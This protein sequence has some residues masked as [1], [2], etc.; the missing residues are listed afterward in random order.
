M[1]MREKS[2]TRKKQRNEMQKW[3]VEWEKKKKKE[4]EAC[5]EH[6]AK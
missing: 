6:T 3:Y 4:I 1:S 5:W 2:V